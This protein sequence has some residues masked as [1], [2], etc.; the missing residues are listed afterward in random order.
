[1][2]FKKE[3][4][5][6][7]ITH[8]DSVKEKVRHQPGC[9]QVILLQDKKDHTVFF[10]YSLWENQS[11]LNLYRNSDFFKEVWVQTKQLFD[12]K[13]EAWSVDELIKL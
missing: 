7:F 9:H 8:F 1:M 11:D 5:T 12:G 2:K 13:P 4:V 6:D 10:T 3:K